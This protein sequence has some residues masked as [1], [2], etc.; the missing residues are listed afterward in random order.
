MTCLRVS[1]LL[2]RSRPPIPRCTCIGIKSS[3]EDSSNGTTQGRGDGSVDGSDA[4]AHHRILLFGLADLN[5][6]LCRKRPAPFAHYLSDVPPS[7][8]RAWRGG[9]VQQLVIGEGKRFFVIA[10]GVFTSG[11]TT[12]FEL[13][14]GRIDSVGM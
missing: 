4:P 7:G 10:G 14:C 13:R 2:E 6:V 8:R 1:T 3:D 12:G 5:R 11:P 9:L